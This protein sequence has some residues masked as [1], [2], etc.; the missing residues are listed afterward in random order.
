MLNELVGERGFEPP[1]PWSRKRDSGVVLNV[2]NL[3][4]WCFDRLSSARSPH[5][6]V[7]VSPRMAVPGQGFI[8]LILTPWRGTGG[9][10]RAALAYPPPAVQNLTAPISGISSGPCLAEEEWLF[11]K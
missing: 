5:S 11:S 8:S 4:Q 2:F 6:G 3:L 1:T 10:F 9:L 7:N